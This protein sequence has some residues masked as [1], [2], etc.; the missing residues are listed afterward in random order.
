VLAKEAAS[1]DERRLAAVMFTDL[2]GYTSLTQESGP[3]ALEVLEKQ[4]TILRPIFYWPCMSSD[5]C[6]EYMYDL[7]VSG[8]GSC[9]K[10]ADHPTLMSGGESWA[11]DYDM[12]SEAS[13]VA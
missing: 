3:L 11:A 4:K 12:I 5:A 8:E 7:A 10:K 13:W 9:W 1:K 2:V 6:L